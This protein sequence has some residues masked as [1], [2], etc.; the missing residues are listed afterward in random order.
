[1]DLLLAFVISMVASMALIPPLMRVAGR[2]HVLDDP[3]SRKV[4]TEPIPRVGGIAMVAGAL[5]PLFIWLDMD[6]T[7]IAY[8]SAAVVLLIFGAWDD[9]VNLHPGIKFTGQLIAVLIVM[10]VGHVS[11]DSLILGERMLLPEWLGFAL[12]LL[13]LLGVTNA[14]NLSDGLDGLAGGTTLLC[15]AALMLLGQSWGVTF[16]VTVSVAL[17][18]SI[19][20]FLRFNTHPARVFMG[21]AGSQFLGFSVGVL[22]ILLTRQ[23]ATPLSTALPLLLIGLPVLDTLAV[24]FMRLQAHKSPF[25]ADRKHF[26]HRLLALG[27]DHHEA[28]IVIYGVQAALLLLAWQLRFE[29]DL[30]IVGA[31]LGIAVLIFG[32]LVLLEQKGWRWRDPETARRRES[33]PLSRGVHWLAAEQRLPRWSARIALLCAGVYLLG[34]A[35]Y[36]DSITEDLGWLAAIGLAALV[37]AALWN[38]AGFADNWLVRG[39]LYVAVMSAVYLDHLTTLMPTPV[40]AAKWIFLPLLALAVAVSFRLSRQRRFE[41]TPLDLLLIFAA[42]ALPNLPG[43]GGAP[44]NFGFS[45]AKLVALCYVVEMIAAMG[46]RLRTALIAVVIAFDLLI[47]VRAF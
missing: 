30:L 25:S 34:I 17:M 37:F 38:R 36:A 32:G 19:L 6:A 45:I 35:A 4:H 24:I 12:T 20:G 41:A 7:L 9:R 18:G 14:I 40:Q 43:L 5:L 23:A 22:C 3:E 44:S 11:I 21:D 2:L 28:V 39:T 1:M 33:S 15:C 8:L 27:V 42:L 13:F 10:L 26:H 31:F 46:S 47:A 29:S 16:V